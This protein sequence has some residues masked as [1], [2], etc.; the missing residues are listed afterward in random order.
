MMG[1][2]EKY[3]TSVALTGIVVASLAI[4]FAEGRIWHRVDELYDRAGAVSSERFHLSGQLES[5][6]RGLNDLVF[7]YSLTPT[8]VLRRRIDADRRDLRQWLAG[9]SDYPTKPAEHELALGA[10]NLLGVYLAHI[11]TYVDSD[12]T[13]PAP[14]AWRDQKEEIVAKFVALANELGTAEKAALSRHLAA[15]QA[16]L[17]S[18]HGAVLVSSV[19]LLVMGGALAL[20]IYR[21]MI[22]PLRRSLE[23]SRRVIERQEKLSALGIL[24]AGVAHEIRNPLTSIKVRLFTQQ[25]L[26]ERGTEAH[27][28]NVFITDEISRLEKI[29]KDFL[30]FARPSDPE[31]KIIPATQPLCEV[32]S[33][34]R[35]GLAQHRLTLK[36]E[37]LADPQIRADPQQLKQVLIN[38]VQNAAE[39]AGP[40]GVVTLRTRTRIPRRGQRGE[41]EVLIE[42][43]DTGPGIPPDVQARIFDPF[44]TTKAGGAGLGL[45]IA[46]RILEK[47]GGRLEY[48]TQTGRGTIFQLVLP[49]VPP[50]GVPS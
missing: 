42:I 44:F 38:L 41:A 45:S 4:L 16:D 1:I 48:Q 49:V 37:Y 30:I 26:L 21:G 25:G 27:E 20:L 34:I 29:V 5:R 12:L 10:E 8:P 39:A 32:E 24:A 9:H 31:F 50:N 47:H 22:A 23:Q 3:R 36:K 28:D 17:K 2:P 18:L 14:Q 19:V 13:D 43:E 15:S 33:L 40:N 46:S 7:R 6:M 11:A 35:P